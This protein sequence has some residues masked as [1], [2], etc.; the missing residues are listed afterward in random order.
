MIKEKYNEKLP[1]GINMLGDNEEKII[2]ILTEACEGK[3]PLTSIL[4]E[5]NITEEAFYFWKMKYL[6]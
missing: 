2:F 3:R 4:E 6:K 1:D 5:N